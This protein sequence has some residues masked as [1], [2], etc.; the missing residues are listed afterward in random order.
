MALLKHVEDLKRTDVMTYTIQLEVRVFGK[1]TTKYFNAQIL[2]LGSLQVT[3]KTFTATSFSFKIAILKIFDRN[4]N[5][6]IFTTKLLSTQSKAELA[7]SNR[8]YIDTAGY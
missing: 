3:L 6:V 8:L 4:M 5:S 7:V 1:T 2:V